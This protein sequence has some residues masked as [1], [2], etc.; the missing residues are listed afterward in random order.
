MASAGSD[1][2]PATNSPLAGQIVRDVV[3]RLAGNSQ[4]GIQAIGGFLARLAG[5]SDQEVMTFMTIPATIS[6]GPSIFQVRMGSGEILSP[7]DR[8]DL[9]VAFYQHS[10]ETHRAQLRDGGVLLY[11]SDHV[12]PDETDKRVRHVGVPITTATVEAVGGNAKDKGKN[13]F[14]LGLLARLFNLNIEKLKGIMQERFGKKSEDILRNALQTFDAGYA[15]DLG[16]EVRAHFAF[17]PARTEST[18]GRPIVTMD[19]NQAIV[20][21]LITGGVRFGAAY[22]ITPASSIMEDLR[23]ALPKYGGMY[24]Q[25][26]DEIA[27]ISIALGFSYSGH[28]A[29]TNTSGPGMSLKMEALGWGIMAEMPLVIVN[30]QRG[31][32]STGLPTMVE[33]SDLL[34]AIGGTHGDAPRIVL[35]PYSVGDCFYAAYEAVQLAKEYSVPV[36]LLSDQALSTRIGAYPQP[37]LQKLYVD[38]GLKLSPREGEYLAYSHQTPTHHVPPGTPMR[39]GKYPLVTGLEHD[40]AGHPNAS[41]PNHQKMTARR[42]EKLKALAAKLPVPE[43]Y[44]DQE[45]D[46]LLVGWGSPF[47]QIREAT[48]ALRAQGRKVGHLHLRHISPLP[49]GLERIFARFRQI[50]VVEINDEGLYGYGQLASLLRSRYANPALRSITKTD[51]LTF[52]VKEILDGVARLDAIPLP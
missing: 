2:L 12:K 31:G 49:N 16:D 24:V 28:V 43:V 36:I 9:L 46:V 7:G 32:P 22:P 26:E 42:R 35:A 37:D 8:S 3:I 39:G 33:Q 25:A 27:A 41:A 21:G 19:G 30:V 18:D 17:G 6:G 44:G 38:P 20:L 47:G 29:V 11:D 5:R 52:K 4:D 45:G 34:Q 48:N 40:E 14:T 1:T 15:H 10:Y 13:I 51:G 23:G 50:D